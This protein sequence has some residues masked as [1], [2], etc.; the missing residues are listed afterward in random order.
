MRLTQALVL[1]LPCFEKVFRIEC[2]ASG[3]DIGGVLTQE[4][5]PFAFFSKKLCNSR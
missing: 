4:G 5:K 2:D 3:V 1:A